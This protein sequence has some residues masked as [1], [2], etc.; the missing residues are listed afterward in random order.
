LSET[1]YCLSRT[2][3]ARMALS[4]SAIGGTFLRG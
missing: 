1:L 4:E 2:V 3:A